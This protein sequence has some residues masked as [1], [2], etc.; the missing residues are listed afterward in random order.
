MTIATDIHDSA[1]T[2]AKPEVAV[3]RL[4][5]LRL[6]Y[7][8][9]AF[10]MGS[11]IWPIVVQ[12]GQLKLM[13]G[14]AFAMLAALS[15]VAVLGIRYPLQMLPLLFFEFMWKATWLAAFALPEAMKGTLPADYMQTVI[16]TAVAIVIPIILPWRYV[17]ENYVKRR[18]DRWW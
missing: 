9:I 13:S 17:I 1:R 15:A 18:G 8:A 5:L 2:A 3:W 10:L 12:H 6:L 11:Q 16:D 7:V 14:V 4:Y